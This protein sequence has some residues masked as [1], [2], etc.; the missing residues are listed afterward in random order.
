MGA[1]KAKA[2]HRKEIP[3]TVSFVTDLAF[4]FT[5]KILIFLETIGFLPRS[6]N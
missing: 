3:D 4:S 6:Y 2:V 5:K 1:D